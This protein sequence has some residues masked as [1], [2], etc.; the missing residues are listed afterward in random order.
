MTRLANLTLERKDD[1]EEAAADD[2][3]RKATYFQNDASQKG[4]LDLTETTSNHLRN[5]KNPEAL[6]ATVRT[7][8]APKQAKISSSSGGPPPNS[9]EYLANT[10]AHLDAACLRSLS[11]LTSSSSSWRG[12][13]A[14]RASDP[15][16]SSGS[17]AL[18]LG[19]GSGGPGTGGTLLSFL[20]AGGAMMLKR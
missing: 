10:K 16:T 18:A 4:E 11:V 19:L 9:R 3:S 6:L 17:F 5:A 14:W 12:L 7:D 1:A 20:K 2:W 8:L 13:I 15:C